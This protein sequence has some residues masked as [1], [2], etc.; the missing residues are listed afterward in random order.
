MTTDFAKTM[1][2]LSDEELYQ[3]AF[4]AADEEF[5]PEAVTAARTEVES[6]GMSGERRRALQAEISRKREQGRAGSFRDHFEWISGPPNWIQRIC[7]G[8]C[9]LLMAI[10]GINL[11]AGWRLFGTYDQAA[12]NGAVALMFALVLF[13]PTVRRIED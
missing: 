6:R 8:I 7:G 2:R 10:T 11:L 5:A 3:I 9:L 4:P 13:F 1:A 12:L